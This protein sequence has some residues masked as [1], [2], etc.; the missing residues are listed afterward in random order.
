MSELTSRA[1]WVDVA[2]RAARTFL[3]VFIPALGL[4]AAVPQAD[5]LSLPWLTA[6]TA[7]AVPTLLSVLMSVASALLPNSDPTSGSFLSKVKRTTK[8]ATGSV[9]VPVKPNITPPVKHV[10]HKPPPTGGKPP[11]SHVQ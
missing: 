4:T 11:T 5:L 2:E 8:K 1:F 6:F 9:H 10:T 7:A 3:Q